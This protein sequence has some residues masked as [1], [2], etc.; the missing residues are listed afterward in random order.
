MSGTQVAGGGGGGISSGGG[1]DMF[2]E[3]KKQVTS[4]ATDIAVLK[5]TVATKEDLH[6]EIS[7]AT[8][9]FVGWMFLIF[10]AFTAVVTAIKYLWS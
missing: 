1:G 7:G 2:D 4:L 10:G 5:A 3:L 9:K 8:S 6:K